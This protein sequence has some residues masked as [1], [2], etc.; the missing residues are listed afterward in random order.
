GYASAVA[1]PAEDAFTYIYAAMASLSLEVLLA[2]NNYYQQKVKSRTWIRKIRLEHATLISVLLLS[3]IVSAATVSNMAEASDFWRTAFIFIGFLIQ[4]M[5]MYLCGYL[6]FFINS[7][8]LVPRVLKVRGMIL[9]CLSVLAVIASLYPIMGQ[10]LAWLPVNKAFGRTIFS[11][12]AFD[13]EN[14]FGAIAVMA[15]SLPI[16]LALQWGRQNQQILKFEKERS[17]TELNLLTQQLNPHFFFNTLNNLYALS[18]RKSD[19]T[20]ESILHLSELMRYTIYK[21]KLALVDLKE[22]VKYIQD[23][24]ELQTIR[25][26][27]KLDLNFDIDIRKPNIQIPPLLLI[28]LVENAFKH[29]V[30]NAEVKARLTIQLAADEQELTFV[31]E[32]SV[33]LI[34]SSPGIGLANMKR[35]LELLYPGKHT[36]LITQDSDT[37]NATLKIRFI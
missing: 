23:F 36:L 30:E 17:D 21:G 26:H 9:Y 2:A 6:L 7:K 12:N 15:F 33:E 20:S 37:F 32:N 19:Q 16:I 8:F 27:H 13:V 1:L 10:L 11:L 3:V 25:L 28:I 31:C 35:R 4:F 34:E 14:A 5:I 29:G 24:I 18:L 22:E